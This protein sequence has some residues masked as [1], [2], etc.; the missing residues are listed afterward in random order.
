M[1]KFGLFMFCIYF[2][3]AWHTT[4]TTLD[5]MSKRLLLQKECISV[6]KYEKTTN[7]DV[8][9]IDPFHRDCPCGELEKK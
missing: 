8:C 6:F 1:I 9:D 7:F 3:Y 2:F 4:S 5:L